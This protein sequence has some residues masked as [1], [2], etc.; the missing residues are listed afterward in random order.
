MKLEELIEIL[1]KGESEEVEFKARFVKDSVKDVCAFSNTGGGDLLFGI[2]DK[3]E[4]VGI[5]DGKIEQ[6]I[7]DALSGI[8]PYPKVKMERLK[9]EDRELFHLNVSAA[10]KLHSV[11]NVV[12]I[13]IGR[14]NRPLNTQEVIEKAAETAIVFFDELPAADLP[15]EAIHKPFVR[16]YLEKRRKIRGI[17]RRGTLE[18]NLALLK[19]AVKKDGKTVPTRG[20]LLF[21]SE[22]PQHY[23]PYARVRL[24]WFEDEEMRRYVDSREF[25]GPLWKI[26]E[27]LEAY[28][29]ANLKVIGGRGAGWKR[30]EFPEYPFD[31]LREAVINALI[32][33]NYF[34]LAETQI[35]IYPSR[36][37]I[38]NPGSFPPGITPEAPAHKPRNPRLSQ[39]MYDFGYIEK[40]GAGIGRIKEECERHPAVNVEFIIRPY[41]TELVFRKEQYRELDKI[42]REIVEVLKVKEDASSTE[43]GKELALSKVTVVNHLK[44]LTSAG[45]VYKTGKGPSTRYKISEGSRGYGEKNLDA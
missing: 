14:N 37:R 15:L 13:R 1:K 31:A 30:E 45:I 7:S 39:Y 28:F 32:H 35:F 26:V 19:I 22:M 21:F 3:G 20:G 29:A 2:S 25:T 33:R 34:D 9:V 8:S 4:I 16:G 27:D 12:Y 43:I 18:E 41:R 42:D 5:E 38:I 11:G 6:K 36:I 40:Y 17:A 23:I 10:D 24:V 44:H